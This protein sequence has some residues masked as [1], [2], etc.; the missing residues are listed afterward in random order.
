M[1]CFHPHG[2]AIAALAAFALLATA[3][4]CR[5]T[6]GD[7]TNP[8]LAPD[9]VPPPATHMLMPGQAQPYYPG[10][11]LPVMQSSTAPTANPVAAN[12]K[13]TTPSLSSSGRLLAWSSPNGVAPPA[14]VS[15]TTSSSGA[16]PSATG[17]PT[18]VWPP[19]GPPEP[20]ALAATGEPAVSIPTDTGSLR[21]E[22]AA[23]TVAKVP[24]PTIA[25]Q[26][27][28]PKSLAPATAPQN[29]TVVPASY[30]APA[31]APPVASKNVTPASAIT[32]V[33]TVP[34]SSAQSGPPT[35]TSSG[36]LPLLGNSPTQPTALPAPPSLAPNQVQYA[37]PSNAMAVQLRAVPS[38]PPAVGDPT[39]LVRMPSY[40]SPTP[41][42]AAAD[43][44]R[45]RTSMR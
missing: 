2:C 27:T 35:P 32:P 9:R 26:P 10:D 4:G 43:G 14:T 11:P 13:Q 15:A 29:Y 42:I 34:M 25:A 22:A 41:S 5:S 7:L 1:R 8:F 24:A 44:F 16:A 3:G 30:N 40:V 37:P 28:S 17:A 21:F 12:E 23:E 31:A 18:S 39:P 33:V 20:N 19:P 45:P 6:S 38:P 36:L